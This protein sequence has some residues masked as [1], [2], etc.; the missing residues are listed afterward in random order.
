M[1]KFEKFVISAISFLMILASFSC[2]QEVEKQDVKPVALEIL[3][4]PAKLNYLKNEKTDYSGL[5]VNMVYTDGSRNKLAENEY[6]ITPSAKTL[7]SEEGSQA[8]KISSDG[9]TAF[10]TISVKNPAETYSSSL[11][12]SSLPNKLSYFTN[13]TLELKG[14]VVK[15]NKTDGTSTVLEE[16]EYTVEPAEGTVLSEDGN[17]A[18]KISADGKTAFFTI[19]V[20]NP[21]ETYSSS[22]EISSLPNKLSYFTNGTLELKGLVVKMNKTDGTSKV[23]SE[24]EYTVEPAEGTVLSEDGSQAVKVSADG[25]TAFFSVYVG[26]TVYTALKLKSMPSKTYYKDNEMFD[27]TGMEVVAAFDDGSERTL[28]AWE[29]KT[30]LQNGSSLQAGSGQKIA[31]TYCGKEVSFYI[32]VGSTWETY[33]FVDDYENDDENSI[34]VK[35]HT[36]TD[37]CR[38]NTNL[39]KIVIPDTIKT[40]ERY[41]FKG[42]T[43]LEEVEFPDGIEI[44][45]EAFN[46]CKSLKSIRFK[47]SVSLSGGTFKDCENIS[48]ELVFPGRIS[49]PG[50]SDSSGFAFE[51]CNNITSVVFSGDGI[52]F[53]CSGNNAFKNCI[54]LESVVFNKDSIYSEL[55]FED[56]TVLK[57]VENMEGWCAV[58]KNCTSLENIK[59]SD[60]VTK[61]PGNA[62]YGCSS[63]QNIDIPNSVIEIREN[64]FTNC[65]KITSIQIP[66]KVE[67]FWLNSFYGCENLQEIKLC[68]ENLSA[69]Y[70]G[71]STDNKYRDYIRDHNIKISY[72][73]TKSQFN[74]IKIREQKGLDD[75]GPR[76]N[77]VTIYCTDGSFVYGE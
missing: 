50:W 14:L 64:A 39:K 60:T 47:G 27:T 53:L 13:G 24:S 22:L 5:V 23:L 49:F 74:K 67:E 41:A 35:N 1:K 57:N 25:K 45:K 43:A 11:E 28:E 7:L 20:K 31:I 32:N 18:V 75:Y 30:S 48:G 65:S 68:S 72:N 29:Y 8:V 63:L 55:Y 54:S 51:N 34:G 77:G 33:T 9:K 3:S 69:I 16:S 26:K 73:G 56:C 59:I 61:I 44:E 2:K 17:Q 42:C 10:F 52:W 21:S 19:S 62:F 6:S 4:L 58:F 12:I 15:M 46:G 38:G 76:L 36:I 40:I 66:Y 71:F 37:I 70:L